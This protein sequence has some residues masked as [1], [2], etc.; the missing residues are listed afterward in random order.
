LNFLSHF[1][2]FDLSDS[3]L[4]AQK[5][6]KNEQISSSCPREKLMHTYATE[7]DFFKISSFLQHDVKSTRWHNLNPLCTQNIFTTVLLDL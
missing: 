1:L 3:Y 7:V 6:K 2:P 4:I 5:I